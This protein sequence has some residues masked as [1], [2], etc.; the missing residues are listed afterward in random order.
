MKV[1]YSWLKELVD[2]E[3]T[4]K[5]LAEK[6]TMVG[7]AVDAVENHEGEEVLEIDLTS[8]RP[9]CLSHLGVAREVAAITGKELR[10]PAALVESNSPDTSSKHVSVEISN[11]ELCPRYT[12][13]VIKGVKV[14]PSPGWL[15]KRLEALGQRSV[16]NIADITN[17]VMLEMGQPLHAFDLRMIR[18]GKIIVRTAIDGE[19][20]VTL[21]GEEREFTSQMLLIADAERALAIGGV[22]GGEDSGISEETT[23]VLLE[24]A[25]FTP[26]HIRQTSKALAL[27]TEA[28]YRY[29]RGTDPEIVP[30]ASNRA[31][32]LMAE[33]AGGTVLPG[34]VDVYPLTTPTKSIS[35]RLSKYVEKTGLKVEESEAIAILER[36][37]MHPVAG[38]DHIDAKSP[39]WRIDIGI[40]E[41][42]IEEV[43]RISGYD[44]LVSTLPGSAGAGGYVP[45]EVHRRAVRTGLAQLGFYEAVSFSFVNGELDSMFAPEATSR[46]ITLSNPIDATQSEMRTTLLS[47]LL[48]AVG[49]NLNYGTRN[50]R[51]FEIGNCFQKLEGAERPL[52][53]QH[54]A[55]AMTGAR[56]ESDWQGAATR[57]DFYDLKGVVEALAELLGLSSLTFGRAEG[58]A[59]LHPERGA[60]IS[61]GERVVGHIGQL[62][63]SLASRLKFKQPI[64]VAELDL[65]VLLES[66]K[67]ETRY[68]S[69]PRFPGISR[70]IAILISRDWSWSEIESAV[71]ALNIEH[72]ESVRLFD[73]YSGSELPSGY[74]SLAISLR[75]RALDRT[76]TEAEVTAVYEQVVNELRSRFEAVL[77]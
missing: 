57:V 1:L 71:K 41:D 10:L 73:L 17:Y 64:F 74:H 44:K 29:E 23:D 38:P 54:L 13:R 66:A 33:L 70:D 37:G 28:S 18:G 63:P 77:R 26:I 68:R 59:Y 3:V 15:V 49:R 42:L 21:D 7:L 30:V 43:A 69:L 48:G 25:Y 31:A 20:M 22:K 55:L 34:L 61:N 8:N 32:S 6:L 53:T 5:E 36:L 45:G 9:D 2:V 40:E 12:A 72:L 47:G 39:S 52:E 35:M 14:G 46:R 67:E 11:P 56:N 51:L 27:A 50:L 58:L 76:L 65:G 62:S 16:N 4:A 19:K 24:A 60:V 75:F